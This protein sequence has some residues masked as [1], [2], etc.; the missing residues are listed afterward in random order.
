[1]ECVPKSESGEACPEM[2]PFK[3]NYSDLFGVSRTTP[4]LPR[5]ESSKPKLFFRRFER[6]FEC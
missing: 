6:I 3:K 1:M 5:S 4:L 2:K